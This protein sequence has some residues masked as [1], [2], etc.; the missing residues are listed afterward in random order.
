MKH[1]KVYSIEGTFQDEQE[2][3]DAEDAIS[4]LCGMYLVDWPLDGTLTGLVKHLNE[5]LTDTVI[6]VD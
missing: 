5:R 1:V 6:V 3:R 2:C 4:W